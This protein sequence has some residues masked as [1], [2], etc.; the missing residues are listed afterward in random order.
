MT[1]R[2]ALALA[3]AVALLGVASP[4]AAQSV[5]AGPSL[6]NASDARL[7][8][9]SGGGYAL[10]ADF[11]VPLTPLLVDALERGV[12]LYFVADFELL[13][14]RWWWFD[15]TRVERSAS[16][17]LAYHALTR[18]YRLTRDGIIRPFDSAADA[19]AA[20]ARLRGWRVVQADEVEPGTLYEARVRLRLDAA[21]LPK[22]FQIGGLASRDWNPQAE[23]KHFEFRP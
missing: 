10:S 20:I 17:R 12:P 19:L 23:W 6:D 22:P 2:S 15:A 16:W 14:P 4:A 8:P 5:T 1:R 18:Q 21:R 11:D 3:L 7:E 13:E 9:A